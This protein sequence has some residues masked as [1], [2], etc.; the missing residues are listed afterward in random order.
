[1]VYKMPMQT[2]QVARY[3]WRS[4]LREQGRSL[5]WLAVRTGISSNTIY[6]YSIGRRRTPDAWLVKAAAALDVPV[7]LL[8][9]GKAA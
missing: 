1:M 9:D 6:A 5:T 4:I 7:D 3:T 2:A 8:R